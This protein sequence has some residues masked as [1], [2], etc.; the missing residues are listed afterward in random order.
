MTARATPVRPKRAEALRKFLRTPKGYVL[1]ALVPLTLF[2]GCFREGPIGLVHAAVAAA[3]ALV[4][5]ALVAFVLRRKVGWSTGGVITGLIIADVLSGLTPLYLVGLVTVIALS[6]KHLLKR[7]RKPIFNPAAVG[8]VVGVW[9]FGTGQSWWAALTLV[10]LWA[11]AAVAVAGVFVAV[12]VKKY[13]QVLAFLGT[14]FGLVMVMALLH[15]GLPSASPADALRVPFVNSAIYLAFFML[16]DPPT[17][18]AQ[19]RGQI[20]F[21]VLAAVVAVVLFMEKGGLTYLLVGLLA[22]NLWTAGAAAWARARHR[23]AAGR[24]PAVLRN[25]L[26]GPRQPGVGGRDGG[27]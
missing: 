19:D 3:T 27:R 2:A 7:G 26:I 20:Q 14:Y 17:S 25:I 11:V 15:L 5:D 13:P 12:R 10:P 23:A 1:T 22:A 8:L 6:S 21:G 24:A 18:P 16:P 4:F 9:A